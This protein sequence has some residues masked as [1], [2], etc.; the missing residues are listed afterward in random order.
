MTKNLEHQ[1]E[2]TYRE[3]RVYLK[4]KDLRTKSAKLQKDLLSQEFSAHVKE[5]AQ[6]WLNKR[7]KKKDA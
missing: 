1:F 5:I 4:S 7:L 2:K 6:D 3:V